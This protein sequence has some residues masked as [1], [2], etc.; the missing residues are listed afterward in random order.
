VRRKRDSAARPSGVSWGTRLRRL[1][2]DPF[3]PLVAF[4]V[5]ATAV[6][7]V[8]LLRTRR[9]PELAAAALLALPEGAVRL[10]MTEPNVLD[11]EAFRGTLAQLMERLGAGAGTRVGLVLPDPVA[12]VVH[13]P[14]EGRGKARRSEAADLLRFRLKKS[15][16]FDVRS[17]RVCAAAPPA[18]L[19]GAG[20]LAG[21]A[22]ESVVDGYE[23]PFRELGLL[24]GLVEVSTLALLGAPDPGGVDG[25]CLL[26]NWEEDFLSLAIS[27]GAWPI[28]VR[29]LAGRGMSE[30]DAVRREV[31]Q[32]VLYHRERLE[33]G[34]LRARVRS[35]AVPAERAS[36]LLEDVL[37]ARPAV[38]EPWEG[39]A[40]F[41][42]GPA[43]QAIAGAVACARRGVS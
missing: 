36:A 32:T 13:L 2:L 40:G 37:G 6:G 10:S 11:R 1:F 25:D 23:E 8:R 39:I 33:G 7:G 19:A 28:L 4:E 43:S 20:P 12:R 29:T 41:E 38:V 15:V 17:A 24:P 35:A 26:I 21:A 27:R 34:P 22:L 42:S 9:G 31:G 30:P 3:R 5:K 16:P 18:G 14:K